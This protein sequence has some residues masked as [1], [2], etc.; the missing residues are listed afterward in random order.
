MAVFDEAE[1]VQVEQRAV[2]GSQEVQLYDV[3]LVAHHFGASRISALYRLKNLRLID[4]REFQRL[5]AQEEGGAGKAI[6]EFLAAPELSGTESSR[7]DFRRRFLGLALEAY[8]R[9]EITQSKLGELAEMVGMRREEVRA[10]LRS[11]TLD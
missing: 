2:P 9:E 1:A 6:A 4:D 5:K 8:R 10:A 3:A 7:E 11:A